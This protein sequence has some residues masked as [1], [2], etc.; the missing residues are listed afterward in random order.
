MIRYKFHFEWFYDDCYDY[1]FDY[2][3]FHFNEK[4]ELIKGNK[5]DW[6]KIENRKLYQISRFKTCPSGRILKI[7]SYKEKDILRMNL[8]IVPK[9]IFVNEIDILDIT[10]FIQKKLFI[11]LLIWGYREKKITSELIKYICF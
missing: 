7:V 6:K 5:K 10:Y 9:N 2:S 11:L 3:S 1:S 4:S 8:R